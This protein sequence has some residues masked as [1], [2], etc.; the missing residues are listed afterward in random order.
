MQDKQITLTIDGSRMTVAKGTTIMEAA[1][2][3]G[4]YI[5]R[6][7]YHP[8]LSLAGSCRVC[9]VE[10]EGVAHYMASCSVP[11]WEGMAVTTNSP[12]I[13]QARRDIVELLLDNHPKDCQT[14][15]RDG[16]C[17]LQNLA[18]SLG[19]RERAIRGPAEAVPHR[20]G[21]QFGGSRPQQVHSLRPLRAGVRGDSGGD[22]SEP[23]RAG[24]RDGRGPGASGRHGR[25]GL[26]P[27]RAVHQRLP[28]GRFPRKAKHRGRLASAGRPD[29]ARRGSDGALD[30]GGDRRRVR[31]RARHALHREDGHGAE[32]TGVRRRVR[33]ELRRRPDHYRGGARVAHP[34]RGRPAADDY[35]LL[36]RLDKLHGEVL[37][38]TDPPRLDLQ[39]ADEHALGAGQ[40]VLRRENRAFRS[41]PEN[42]RGGRD[43]LRGEE[44]RVASGPST[45][46]PPA[47][48]TPTPC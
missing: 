11:V 22:E 17:E 26:H 41:R 47:F 10:V 40:D 14:C 5:P 6:L 8:D 25:I 31:L 4:V 7:C 43:A 15:E 48:L 24:V 1:E 12:D 29:H 16:R 32:A 9:I 3:L 21:Q 27:V 44:V 35:L 18:Y 37:S 33:H 46:R 45:S 13:R 19:V 2:R 30:S 36:A 38:G 20:R 42:L 23:A 28:H 34:A 39:I